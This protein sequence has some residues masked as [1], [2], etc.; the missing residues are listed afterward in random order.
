MKG[1]ICKRVTVGCDHFHPLFIGLLVCWW[2]R[3]HVRGC[4]ECWTMNG[5]V[6]SID[7]WRIPNQAFNVDV[8]VKHGYHDYV[9][10]HI[11][12]KTILPE[13]VP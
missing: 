4:G 1:I 13:G 5:Q 9:C 6:L 11:L 3:R 8:S 7:S 12:T 10:L 2:R